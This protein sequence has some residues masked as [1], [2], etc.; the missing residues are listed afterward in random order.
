MVRST[1]EDAQ[2]LIRAV[3]SAYSATP[4]NLKVVCSLFPSAFLQKYLLFSNHN[5]TLPVDY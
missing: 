3:W 2:D 4:T 1:T 5:L